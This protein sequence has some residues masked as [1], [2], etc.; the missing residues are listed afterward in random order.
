MQPFQRQIAPTTFDACD[1]QA[2]N[3]PLRTI[4]NQMQTGLCADK[5]SHCANQQQEDNEKTQADLFKQTHNSGPKP[6]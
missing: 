6:M 5:E 1:I 4:D 2:G 3:N